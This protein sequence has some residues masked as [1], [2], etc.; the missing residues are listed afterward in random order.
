MGYEKY[1]HINKVYLKMLV[2]QDF[3]SFAVVGMEPAPRT[4]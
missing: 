1:S 2:C 4:G 3:I